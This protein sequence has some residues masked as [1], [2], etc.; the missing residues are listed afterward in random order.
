MAATKMELLAAD[1]GLCIV[2]TTLRDGEQTPG[3]AFN[4]QEKVRIAKLL[5]AIG[6]EQIEAGTPIMGGDE[7]AAVKAIAR[8]GLKASIMGWNRAV[9]GDIKASVACGV[10]AVEISSPVSDL[11]IVHK[12]HSSRE[13]VIEN[14]VKAVEYAKTQ[15]LYVS[16]GA[17]DAS[18]SDEAF[19]AEYAAAVKAAGAHRLRYCDTIGILGPLEIFARI[20]RLRSQVAIDIEIHS[21]N[22]FGLATANALAAFQAGAK[23]IDATVNGLGE[24][25]G[26]AALEE[27]VMGLSHVCRCP[28][29]YNAAR[30]KEACDYVADASGRKL[31]PGKA[32]VGADIFTH[33]SGVHAAGV[34]K[35]PALYEAYDPA[36]IGLQ[37]RIVLGKHSGA[38]AVIHKLSELGLEADEFRAA[39][40]LPIV[41]DLAV[42]LK[43]PP[44][45]HELRTLAANIRPKRQPD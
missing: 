12:L 41:R 33:E 44:S 31:P 36:L 9:I 28:V 16:V 34:L 21:H 23:F 39:A 37:R 15:G 29:Y 4:K 17:E 30:L 1:R 3:V 35:N 19:L 25:A 20:Q 5:D 22:D 24:R 32:V 43:R 8:L 11:H 38:A 14:T 42:R 40:L 10:D 45:E 13:K 2:D 6:V 26:N 27:V 18:R 7:A